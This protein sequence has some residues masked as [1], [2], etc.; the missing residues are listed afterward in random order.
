MVVSS[1]D[2][3]NVED[4]AKATHVS[5]CRSHR[6]TP[7]SPANAVPTNTTDQG[8]ATRLPK[9]S[10]CTQA[11]AAVTRTQAG[12]M[13]AMPR[14]H[15]LHCVLGQLPSCPDEEHRAI[16]R[17][18]E[19]GEHADQAGVPVENTRLRSRQEIGE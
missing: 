16:R 1:S 2:A 5:P 9:T 4:A 10:G 7:T 11:V 15:M 13:T 18:Q 17:E 8:R 12:T 14:V 19:Q 3:M 6:N